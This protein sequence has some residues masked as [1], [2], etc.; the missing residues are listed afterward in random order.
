MQAG[1]RLRA[2]AMVASL[3]CAGGIAMAPAAAAA[4]KADHQPPAKADKTLKPAH[5]SPQR[6]DDSAGGDSGS[7]SAPA[8]TTPAATHGSASDSSALSSGQRPMVSSSAEAPLAVVHAEN[9]QAPGTDAEA[10]AA[11]LRAAHTAH[12]SAM[13]SDKH[14]ARR[15]ETAA[16]LIRSQFGSQP[17]AGT[18]ATSA[19][20]AGEVA[21]L[22][23]EGATAPARP[24]QISRGGPPG[25]PYPPPPVNPVPNPSAGGMGTTPVEL[26]NAQLNWALIAVV[27]AL[28]VGLG[29]TIRFARRSRGG[30]S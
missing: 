20:G 30:P 26:I 6:G 17:A 9:E 22:L 18:T 13:L 27:L 19:A 2:A 24:E 5:A 7:G 16:Q 4:P 15:H 23:Q 11:A 25:S 28:A 3:L 10:T 14:A 1:G 21:A 29:A 8:M 12:S